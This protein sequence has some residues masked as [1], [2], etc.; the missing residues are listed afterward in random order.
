MDRLLA[1]KYARAIYMLSHDTE[2]F[3]KLCEDLTKLIEIWEKVDGFKGM[4]G[5]FRIPKSLRLETMARIAK[6]VNLDQNLRNLTCLLI[7]KHHF[8]FLKEIAIAS[9]NL[10]EASRHEMRVSVIT[11]KEIEK[12]LKNEIENILTRAVQKNVK[13]EN[14]IDASMIGG[15]KLKF[16]SKVFDGSVE[17]ELEKMRLALSQ[18]LT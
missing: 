10:L 11:A 3:D 7:E 13:I 8:C 12:D 2:S 9:R 5:D 14:K 17:K 4:I 18:R 1:K 15:I 6:K 16:N